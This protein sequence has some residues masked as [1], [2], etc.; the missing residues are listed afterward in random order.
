MTRLAER[1]D[2]A[3]VRWIGTARVVSLERDEHDEPSR[4]SAFTIMAT[5]LALK[6]CANVRGTVSKDD[7]ACGLAVAEK[8]DGFAIGEHQIR[9]V[10]RDRVAFRQCVE[11]LA[12]LVD[13]PC[14]QSTADRQNRG[15]AVRRALYLQY[16]PICAGR[17][18]WSISQRRSGGRL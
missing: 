8:P 10:D 6:P 16:Q 14:V 7:C 15:R 11:R 9:E 13:V 17:N 5:V 1:P 18:S 12:Q 3:A 2:L 4:A